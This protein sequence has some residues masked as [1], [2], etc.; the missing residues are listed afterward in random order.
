MDIVVL[1]NTPARNEE[2]QKKVTR[3]PRAGKP[4]VERRRNRV[5]RRQ[6]VRDGITVTISSRKERR[7][8]PDRRSTPSE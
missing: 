2:Q 1:G 7:R 5:D 8:Q 3:V 4:I 6:S